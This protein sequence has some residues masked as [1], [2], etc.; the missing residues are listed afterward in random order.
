M[1]CVSPGVV[2]LPGLPLP[3]S[4]ADDFELHYSTFEYETIL[5]DYMNWMQNVTANKVR[6]AMCGGGLVIFVDVCHWTG[7]QP[8][9]RT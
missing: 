8:R 7:Q 9:P 2:I 5:N 3:H 1:S 4:Y 6:R